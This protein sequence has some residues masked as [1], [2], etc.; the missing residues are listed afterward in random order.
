M[1]RTQIL[2]GIL[3]LAVITA[4]AA[5]FFRNF[6]EVTETVHT[7]YRGAAL[8][9]PL[10]AAERLLVRMGAKASTLR[11]IP[12]LRTLPASATLVLPAR[13]YI[14]NRSLQME[15]LEWV[16]KGGYLIVEAEPADEPDPLLDALKVQRFAV[17][18]P[19]G[20]QDSYAPVQVMLP[21]SDTASRVQLSRRMRLEAEAAEYRFDDGTGNALILVEHGDG[22]VMVLNELDFAFN[23]FIG[24][25]QHA[26]FLWQMISIVPGDRPVFLFSNSGRLSLRDWL[27]ENAWAP[28]SGGAALL[29]LWLWYVG[30]RLGP[31]APDP[32]RNRRRLLDHLR[33]SGRFLWSSGG[34]QRMLD[35]AR[36]SC[37]RRIARAH[38]DFLAISD[39]ERPQR[40]AEILGWPEPRARQLLVPANA[41]KMMD[42]LQAIAL[43]QAVHEQLALKARASSRKTR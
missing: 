39:A 40:L 24:E 2:V 25:E 34:A 32:A 21:G 22:L 38:P 27:Q 36:D 19:R 43:Y 5:W 12:E 4:G 42:F 6:E 37:L 26:R 10:L 35:A 8:R 14:L 11:S 29:L 33:A 17:R 13:R 16:G 41:A 9:N 28:L 15:L 30:P 20:P 31:I 1:S 7:G 3:V 23:P 18:I